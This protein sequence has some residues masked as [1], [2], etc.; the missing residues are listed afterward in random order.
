M[1]LGP[2]HHSS[3]RQMSP[4]KAY[5]MNTR[6]KRSAG[7]GLVFTDGNVEA[8]S[9]I[10]SVE[11]KTQKLQVMAATGAAPTMSNKPFRLEFFP[12]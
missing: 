5:K 4:V 3:P 2:A 1:S 9:M 12:L 11:S 6:R 7:A 8:A 10:Q